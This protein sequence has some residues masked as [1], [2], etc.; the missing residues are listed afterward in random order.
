MI[1]LT[2]A[3]RRRASGFTLIE[4]MVAL[5]ILGIV[6]AIAIPL[7][8]DYVRRSQ[9]AEAFV[10]VTKFK[11]EI[12]EFWSA[13][14]RLPS[15][16]EMRHQTI[17]S[18]AYVK[19]VR[20]R[21][22]L[23]ALGRWGRNTGEWTKSDTGMSRH[24]RQKLESEASSYN[25]GGSVF[26][27]MGR[28]ADAVLKKAPYNQIL[29]TPWV[30]PNG[31]ITWECAGTI[32][33]K[34][35]PP[36]CH[37][38]TEWSWTKELRGEWL[39]EK[40]ILHSEYP[41]DV[42]EVSEE[43]WL[44]HM[45]DRAAK[46]IDECKPPE[47]AD[48]DETYRGDRRD[49]KACS[50]LVANAMRRQCA[51]FTPTKRSGSNYL[52]D[53][54]SRC[55]YAMQAFANDAIGDAFA[56]TV[57]DTTFGR[58]ADAFRAA[59][60]VTGLSVNELNLLIGY[61]S[62]DRRDNVWDPDKIKDR[63]NKGAY[64]DQN[65][66][67]F[68]LSAEDQAALTH[69]HA[70]ENAYLGVMASGGGGAD[71][72]D[73]E[74]IDRQLAANNQWYKLLG[75]NFPGFNDALSAAQNTSGIEM[76]DVLDALALGSAPSNPLDESGIPITRG[77]DGVVERVKAVRD[78][79]PLIEFAS[80]TGEADG[81][82]AFDLFPG[83]DD[84]LYMDDYSKASRDIRGHPNYDSIMDNLKEHAPPEMAMAVENA[85][86]AG[87][88][89]VA[90]ALAF[91]RIQGN[92][93]ERDPDGDPWIGGWRGGPKAPPVG[94]VWDAKE[95]FSSIS[96]SLETSESCPLIPHHADVTK[97][98]VEHT[99][100]DGVREYIDN[101]DA[102]REA[103]EAIDGV[104]RVTQESSESKRDKDSW[105]RTCRKAGGCI[106]NDYKSLITR[107]HIDPVISDDPERL[108]QVEI[109]IDLALA[110]V[111]DSWDGDTTPAYGHGIEK[112]GVGL[113]PLGRVGA[114]YFE[115]GQ[116]AQYQGTWS[117]KTQGIRSNMV[118]CANGTWGKG[119]QITDSEFGSY[120]WTRPCPH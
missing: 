34:Y 87:S 115:P 80:A 72:E 49:Q 110:T 65:T 38:L 69:A 101:Q 79:F 3:S 113:V 60:A 14:E 90:D 97:G 11:P 100:S 35:L 31:A 96:L 95:K 88:T 1:P 114:G 29:L 39:A 58:G 33:T 52:N 46:H 112:V 54:N 30:T 16:K 47:S 2:I 55:L 120:A 81:R 24:W 27:K 59:M 62:S 5:G 28:E 85:L 78:A 118:L 61:S 63:Y 32:P 75:E 4:I 91:Q 15:N 18:G 83:L 40:G 119:S 84:P 48:T 103:L 10:L 105:G 93:Q 71:Q 36:N 56:R 50:E 41:W 102:V 25:Y 53:D 64:V 86:R 111:G 76:P 6:A 104:S 7:Y 67:M 98:V 99:L 57:A 116:P 13:N 82:S 44:Q 77:K 9:V 45:F 26:M 12:G 42:K 8:M 43:E 89:V 68:G 21:T 19:S 107:Y 108:A 109:Q 94:N 106:G 23:K 22:D 17:R 117:S 51:D 74:T 37:S 66:I 73:Y 92:Y 20:W 70:L